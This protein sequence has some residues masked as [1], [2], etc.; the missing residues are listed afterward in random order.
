LVG[1]VNGARDEITG[2]LSRGGR[3]LIAVDVAA[4]TDHT[5]THKDIRQAIRRGQALHPGAALIIDVLDD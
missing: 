1:P 4:G 5:S 2:V 3:R